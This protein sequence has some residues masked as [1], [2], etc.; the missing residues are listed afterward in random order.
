MGEEAVP[1]EVTE[2]YQV[3]DLSDV[4]DALPAAKD[5]LLSVKKVEPDIVKGRDTGAVIKRGF[6]VQLSIVEGIAGESGELGYRNKVLFHRIPYWV[7]TT[8]YASDMYTGANKA[9]LK[10][11]KEFLAALGYD[12]KQPP[13]FNDEFYAAVLGKQVRGNITLRE[14]RALD[15]STGKWEGTGDKRNEVRGLKAA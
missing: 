3:G 4:T 1:F 8:V 2:E 13:K 14:I 7:D 6:N 15:E 9:F 5:V 10:P 11:L 12:I